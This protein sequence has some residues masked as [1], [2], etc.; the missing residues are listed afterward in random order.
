MRKINAFFL[1][2]TVALYL[3][4]SK[5]EQPCGYL[6]RAPGAECLAGKFTIAFEVEFAYEPTDAQ[7]AHFETYPESSGPVDPVAQ[8]V[9]AHFGHYAAWYVHTWEAG[10]RTAEVNVVPN[11]SCRG[12]AER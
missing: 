8:C 3:P 1:C 7:V 4:Q 5:A 2:L 6:F 12:K 9:A 10:K 11:S